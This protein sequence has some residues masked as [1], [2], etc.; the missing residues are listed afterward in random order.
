MITPGSERVK[1]LYF[2][3][4]SLEEKENFTFKISNIPYHLLATGW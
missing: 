4:Y 1:D 2:Q 3:D